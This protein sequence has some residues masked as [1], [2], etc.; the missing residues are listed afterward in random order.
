MKI[1]ELIELLQKQP[2]NAE[3]MICQDEHTY[4]EIDVEYNRDGRITVITVD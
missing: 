4:H 3:I 1:S 2:E